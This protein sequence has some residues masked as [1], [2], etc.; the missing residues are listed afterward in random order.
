MFER[1]TASQ[2]GKFVWMDGAFVPVE[3]AKLHID[4]ECVMRGANVFEGIRG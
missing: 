2:Q 1:K 3:D 4:T